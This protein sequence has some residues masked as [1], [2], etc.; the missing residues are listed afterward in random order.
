M[1]CSIRISSFPH[2]QAPT[3]NLFRVAQKRHAP[4]LPSRSEAV[5]FRLQ[6]SYFLAA[7]PKSNQKTPPRDGGADPSQKKKRDGSVPCA[8]QPERGPPTGHP[9]PDVG[10]FGI[11]PRPAPRG[12]GPYRSD[13]AVLG[14]ANGGRERQKQ[15]VQVGTAS[16][17][18][19]FDIGFVLL[20]LF[21]LGVGR[22]KRFRPEQ[23]SP[24]TAPSTASSWRHSA[25]ACV[26]AGRGRMPKRP[27][28]G[29]G[30]P[31]GGPRHERG[32]QGT[33][34]ALVLLREGRS[35]RVAA[36]FGYFLALLPKSN[37]PVGENPRLHSA[38]ADARPDSTYQQCS[39]AGICSI[40]LRLRG[41][42][43]P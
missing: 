24:V 39:A 7:A 32:A 36:F 26:R 31:V 40:R 30:W 23:L 33:P 21:S 43:K 5:D 18:D 1:R 2:P 19:Y 15:T 20:L 9:W 35:S 6:A 27:T 37:S 3:R 17:S 28:S 12:A 34:L 38:K 13:F 16:G 41:D 11:L 25:G 14:A 29:H 10:R 42:D 22:A 8:P 4:R